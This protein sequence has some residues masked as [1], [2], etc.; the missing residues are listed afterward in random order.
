MRILKT[1]GL[2]WV[3]NYKGNMRNQDF[4]KK[5]QLK[6]K[7]I[8]VC[9][10]KIS[11]SGVEQTGS[12]QVYQR[13]LKHKLIFVCSKKISI[14]GVEQTGSTQV[15][16]RRSHGERRVYMDETPAANRFL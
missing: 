15:Y 5:R 8:F 1:S 11:I 10:K 14:S 12:T 2:P 4:A 16:Q 7:L 13:R 3:W 9:S 6:H